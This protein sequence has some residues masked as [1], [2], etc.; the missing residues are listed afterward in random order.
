MKEINFPRDELLGRETEIV[1]STDRSLIGVKGR[2]IDETKNTF[3]IESNGKEMRVEKKNSRFLFRK[4]GIEV[5][6]RLLV[7]RGEE[8]LK[9]GLP[10]KWERGAA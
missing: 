10:G 1:N 7:G 3:L 8:R 6:G 4:D 9:K 2:I 5:E